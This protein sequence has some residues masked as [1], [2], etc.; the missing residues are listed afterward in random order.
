[1]LLYYISARV[2]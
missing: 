1:C 2:F